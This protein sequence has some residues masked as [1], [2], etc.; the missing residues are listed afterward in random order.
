VDERGWG[1]LSY[2]SAEELE[3][4]ALSTLPYFALLATWRVLVCL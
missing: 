4:G 3:E 2:N 1:A